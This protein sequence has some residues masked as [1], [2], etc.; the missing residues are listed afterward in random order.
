MGIMGN[1][2]RT[3]SALALLAMAPALPAAPAP[4]PAAATSFRVGAFE[5]VALRD[6]LNVVPNDGSVFGKDRTPAAVA[7]VLHA[8]GA[9]AGSVTLAVDA[10]LV[11]EPGRLVLIDTGLGPKAGGALIA[12]LRLAGVAPDAVTDVLLTHGHR[13]HIGGLVTAQGR[14]A[15]PGA[16]IRFA[17]AEWRALG[18]QPEA[19]AIV[20]A[21]A[22]QVKTF[23]P[24]RPVLPGITPLA[25][26]GHTPG[27]VG[28]EIASRGERL[29]DIG[30]TAHSAIVSLA[31]PDWAIGYD[32]DPRLGEANRRALLTRLAAS[33]QRVFA[34]HFPYPG[35][36]RIV[37]AGTGFAWSPDPA[38]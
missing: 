38:K 28:Y 34:P 1:G 37:A 24:G 19:A 8:A 6:M 25:I 5:L 17:A 3:A 26:P 33:H 35:V 13:D 16:T 2:I 15:F 14:S 29:L 7:A 27:H 36:G 30:D 23:A 11:R 9:P 22:A 21:I 18:E 32:G 10:L 31:R 4:A 12:S 20:R